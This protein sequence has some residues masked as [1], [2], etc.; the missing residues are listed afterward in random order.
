MRRA[1]L[2]HM[3][4]TDDLTR[5]AWIAPRLSGWGTVSCVVPT[6]F[7]AYA[8]VLHPVT[9]TRVIT[10]FPYSAETRR[11]R[12]ADV[13]AARGT[14]VHPAVQW[15]ALAGESDQGVDV[16]DDWAADAPS[17]GDLDVEALARLAGLLAAAGPTAGATAA[18]WTGFGSLRPASIG[19]MVA[20]DGGS[21]DD[22]TTALAEARS[23]LA[24]TVSDA[25]TAALD[26]PLLE[27]PQ[28]EYLLLD[29][30]VAEFAD[31]AWTERAGI[32]WHW[33][34]GPTP[35]L[36]WPADRSWCLGTEIDFDST[37]IGGDRGLIDAVLADPLLEA[38]EVEPSTDLSSFGDSVNG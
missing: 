23:A 38:L 34:H 22:E 16:G 37:L 8:R 13:A 6:G 33:G 3:R 12:W 7:A 26:G 9:A 24:A 36:L 11:L 15:A 20:I 31:P 4:P 19:L 2:A 18:V 5:A 28:R 35:N 14:T 32:G 29:C 21:A 10:E 1:T 30:D 17:V 27:L 25:V